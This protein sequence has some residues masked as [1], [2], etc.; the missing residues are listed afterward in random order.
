MHQQPCASPPKAKAAAE[1]IVP[2]A[3]SGYGQYPRTF[4]GPRGEAQR[5]RL[6]LPK[7]PHVR[8]PVFAHSRNP[9]GSLMRPAFQPSPT[10]GGGGGEREEAL[11]LTSASFE[12]GTNAVSSTAATA[13]A[14]ASAVRESV[15]LLNQTWA[16]YV[17]AMVP[18]EEHPGE[19]AD[20]GEEG[21][22]GEGGRRVRF[23]FTLGSTPSARGLHP[24]HPAHR[25]RQRAE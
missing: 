23:R 15:D 12:A 9:D 7:D 25:H 10:P 19:P 22:E 2:I 20:D 8:S 16:G 14:S 4:G 11:L 18:D 13:V 3:S 1:R 5:R 17:E 21:G 6:G 24:T